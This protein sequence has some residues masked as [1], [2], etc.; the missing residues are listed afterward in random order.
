MKVDDPPRGRDRPRRTWM[1]VVK[2][3]MKKCN[4]AEYLAQD[5]LEW[6]NKIRI[7]DLNIV[8]TRL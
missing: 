7:A 2:I 6:R 8:G 5:R 4:L 3:D 1:K